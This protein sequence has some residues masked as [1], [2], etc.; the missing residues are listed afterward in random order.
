MWDSIPSASRPSSPG[1]F[2]SPASLPSLCDERGWD[3]RRLERSAEK[4][5]SAILSLKRTGGLMIEPEPTE[6]PPKPERKPSQAE[7]AAMIADE[8]GETEESVRKKIVAIA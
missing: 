2:P 1:F 8:L 5:E 3:P 7:V 6:Q 4:V